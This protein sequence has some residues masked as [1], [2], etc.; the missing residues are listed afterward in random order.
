MKIE[1]ALRMRELIVEAME[2]MTVREQRAL[3]RF[4]GKLITD[5]M[6]PL[7]IDEALPERMRRLLE[8]ADD[9]EAKKVFVAQMYI[10]NRRKRG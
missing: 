4:A 9:A 10:F 5:S 1:N 2:K 8:M 6:L 3:C 7:P